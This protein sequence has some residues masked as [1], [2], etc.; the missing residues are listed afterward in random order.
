MSACTVL[1]CFTGLLVYCRH[2]VETVNL[3]TM[4]GGEQVVVMQRIISSVNSMKLTDLV[5]T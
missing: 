2:Y 4:A 5:S 1:L 3:H